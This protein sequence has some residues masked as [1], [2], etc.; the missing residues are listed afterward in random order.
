MSI[1]KKILACIAFGLVAIPV[2]ASAAPLTVLKVDPDKINCVFSPACSVTP[3]DTM[4]VFPAD[5]GFT[6]PVR[7]QSRT[8]VGAAKSKAAGKTA[9]IYRIDM[10]H[11]VRGKEMHCADSMDIDFG[12]VEKLPYGA[13]GE[14]GDVF[15]INAGPN[16]SVGIKKASQSKN[17][18]SIEFE[19]PIC[20]ANGGYPGLTSFFFGLASAKAPVAG[21]AKVYL[22]FGGGE[23]KVPDRQPAH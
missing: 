21:I 9:Y 18:V 1:H 8:Y 13:K 11:A 14:I 6:G 17:N 2:T 3:A 4:G 7:M 23:S 22:T 5:H 20:P 19:S 15:V 12:P 10:T 16:T